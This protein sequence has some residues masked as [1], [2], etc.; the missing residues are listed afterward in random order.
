MANREKCRQLYEFLSKHPDQHVQASWSG[1][2]RV[3]GAQGTPEEIT[4]RR[5]WWHRL[6]N[7]GGFVTIKQ[8]VESPAPP[9]EK[10]PLDE[11]EAALP[12]RITFCSAGAAAYLA[13]K[14]SFDRYDHQ[15]HLDAGS[16]WDWAEVGQ[17]E[18]GLSS[19]E[20]AALFFGCS[21]RQ[22]LAMLKAGAEGRSMID[23]KWRTC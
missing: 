15:A 6:R 10:D 14:V 23:A 4:P 9:Q 3:S 1:T 5:R 7:E 13:G 19:R 18:L 12:E 11:L 16:G 21:E 20:A 17:H 8:P 2:G 22:A